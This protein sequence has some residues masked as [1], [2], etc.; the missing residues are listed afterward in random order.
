[1]Y[2]RVYPDGVYLEPDQQ[3]PTTGMALA[4]HCAP[5]GAIVEGFASRLEIA[6]WLEDLARKVR[7]GLINAEEGSEYEL[8]DT[9]SEESD[10]EV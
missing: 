4:I 5:E 7:L 10:E 9:E 3:E 8:P 1:M 2:A 6:E